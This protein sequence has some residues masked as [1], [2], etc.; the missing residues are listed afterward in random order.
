M[1]LPRAA[2]E[3]QE[4]HPH[5]GEEA[6]PSIPTALSCLAFLLAAAPEAAPPVRSAKITILSTMLADQGMGEWGFSALV[7]VDG[8]RLLFDT[9][10]QPDTVLRNAQVLGIDLSDVTDVVLSHSHWDHV[11]GLATL[12]KALSPRSP[13]ALSRVHVGKGFFAPR[14]RKGS[15]FNPVLAARA[16]LE[17][18]GVRFIEHDGPSQLLPGVWLTG[19]VP[20]VHPERNYPDDVFVDSPRGEVVDP[21]AEDSSLVLDTKDGLVVLTGCGHAGVI[22]TLEAA[23]AAVRDAKVS[24]VLGGL[25]LFAADDA[26]LDWTAAQFRRFGVREMV[27][28]HCTG[29]EAVH[30]LRSQAGLDRRT[31]VVGAV[32]ASWQLGKG[33]DPGRLA[34]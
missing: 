14:T 16:E 2:G 33:I 21:V 18:S 22:N 29:I 27:G 4:G 7:E 9:G 31:A 13:S 34:R 20:R 3:L 30:R 11:G 28:A 25:H 32:G 19:P 8:K 5:L 26:T 15:P 6:M 23:R 17:A 12:R 24:T 10:G 1:G